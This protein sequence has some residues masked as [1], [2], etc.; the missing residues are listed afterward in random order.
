MPAAM[1]V[2][3]Y[4]HTE[5]ELDS[6]ELLATNPVADLTDEHIGDLVD[7]DLST[8]RARGDAAATAEPGQR[9]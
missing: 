1:T 8:P 7:F 2:P 9:R 6:V 3:I 5:R 4:V